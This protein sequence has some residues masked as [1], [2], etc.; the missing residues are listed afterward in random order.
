LINSGPFIR[1][2]GIGPNLT[3]PV[4]VGRISRIQ[5]GQKMISERVPCFVGPEPTLDLGFRLWRFVVQRIQIRAEIHKPRSGLAG[6]LSL[7]WWIATAS[8]I[9]GVHIGLMISLQTHPE[10][11]WSVGPVI[12]MSASTALTTARRPGSTAMARR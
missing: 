4:P 2:R 7:F 3:N 9:N 10:Q 12:E 8:P 1:V 6:I 11:S 5:P